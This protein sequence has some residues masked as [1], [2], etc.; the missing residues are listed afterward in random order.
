VLKT[1]I[2]LYKLYRDRKTAEKIVRRIHDLAKS[3]G[4]K[5]KIMNFC[6][7]HE[8]TITY[9]GI[10]SLMPENIELV[11]GPGCPVCI[12]PARY[13]DVCV[14]LALSGITVFTYGDMY[15][16]PGSKLSLAEARSRGGKVKVVYGF[17]DVLKHRELKEAVFFG[18]G[19][20]TTQ[21]TVASR[22][23]ENFVPNSLKI[24]SAYRLTPPIMRY[25]LENNVVELHGV[26]AP[27]HVSTIIGSSSWEF[28]PEEFQISTV[29]AGFEPIDVLLAILNIVE[30]I[31]SG[32]AYL[33]NE[34]SRVVKRE[35]NILA[36]KYVEECFEVCD[37]SWRGIGVVSRSGLS[38]RKKYEKYD[39]V[40]EYGLNLKGGVDVKPGC[41]C[42]DV[43]L[44]KAKPTD[45]PFFMKTC[46]PRHP[47]GP[48]MVSSEG[49]CSIWA[50]YGSLPRNSEAEESEDK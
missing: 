48:C 39:A 2:E 12:V 32:K 50:R 33:Y 20:E 28:L 31:F 40:V 37:A 1:P 9:Y 22:I 24:L 25:L 4:Y 3:I 47:Y 10:R 13:I 8:Y 49:T 44:G 11:A 19:F 15:R 18:V 36:K 6:G 38:F 7:T 34:Y 14:D 42:S 46:T 43:I 5:I 27:G 45:C 30:Q 41:R 17:L 35:G 16:V 21:P 26:I 23:A 29:V